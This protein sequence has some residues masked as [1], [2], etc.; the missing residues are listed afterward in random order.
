MLNNEQIE[1]L[2]SRCPHPARDVSGLNVR[3]T[4]WSWCVSDASGAHLCTTTDI[5]VVG[6]LVRLESQGGYGTVEALLR[7]LPTLE[8]LEL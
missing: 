3:W 8:E 1:T 4:G 2:R 5:N 6:E 7:P